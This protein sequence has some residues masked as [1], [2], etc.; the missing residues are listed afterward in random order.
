LWRF[1][2]E[3]ARRRPETEQSEGAQLGASTKRA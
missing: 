2:K 1:F 3:G